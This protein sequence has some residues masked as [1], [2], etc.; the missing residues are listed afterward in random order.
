M[1]WM[2]L[3]LSLSFPV[4]ASE[5]STS[6]TKASFREHSSRGPGSCVEFHIWKTWCSTNLAHKDKGRELWISPRVSRLSWQKFWTFQG[7]GIGGLRHSYLDCMDWKT[8]SDPWVI[9]IWTGPLKSHLETQ[10]SR[11]KEYYL[12]LQ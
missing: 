9:H 5:K 2:M 3:S 11:Q 10:R 8:P 1:E 4:K 6:V 7:H 12:E